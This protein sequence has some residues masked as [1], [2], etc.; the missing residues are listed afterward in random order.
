MKKYSLLVLLAFLFL[1]GCYTQLA[2]REEEYSRSDEYYDEGEYQDSTY[3]DSL[4]YY[5][6]YKAGY[7]YGSMTGKYLDYHDYRSLRGFVFR[8]YPEVSMSYYGS[9]FRDFLFWD[10]PYFGFHFTW[11]SPYHHWWATDYYWDR[12]WY[13]DYWFYRDYYWYNRPYYYPHWNGGNYPGTSYPNVTR[14]RETIARDNNGERGRGRTTID[15]G[16]NSNVSGGDRTGRIRDFRGTDVGRIV[17]DRTRGGQD[18]D[19]NQ[20]GRETLRDRSKD[21]REKIYRNFER[22]FGRDYTGGDRGSVRNREN[23][24]GNETTSGGTSGSGR[25]RNE[26]NS[27][28]QNGRTF[29]S[30]DSY[31]NSRNRGGS[32]NDSYRDRSS[33]YRPSSNDSYYR[34]RSGSS[35]SGGG[36]YR[37]SGSSSSGSSSSGSSSSG[38]RSSSST[39]SSSRN[40]S[41]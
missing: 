16:R 27:Y 8:N 40:T 34:D 38:S 24:G 10:F 41:R 12:Y 6:S 17:S 13:N 31:D 23:G 22:T 19:G 29:R 25:N 11:D 4:D 21:Y 28:W 2:V 20:T 32:S 5:D 37:S 15:G 39:G 18:N 9:Y 30:T 14:H 26:D 1:Q 36:S 35:S 33:D 3:S 7:S